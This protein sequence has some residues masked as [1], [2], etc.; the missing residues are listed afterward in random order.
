MLQVV[1]F[2]REDAAVS[3]QSERGTVMFN[4]DMHAM[5]RVR[6]PPPQATVH[7]PHA[8]ITIEYV[9]QVTLLHDWLV[10]GFGVLA[11]VQNE[12]ATVALSL[13]TQDT[14]RVCVPP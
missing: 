12:S 1:V 3:L 10:G 8:S 4:E 2:A 13:E 9:G 6:V 7:G 11:E 5:L 14:V